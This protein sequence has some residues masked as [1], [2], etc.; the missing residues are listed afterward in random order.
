MK[1]LTTISELSIKINVSSRTLRHWEDMGLFQSIR[2]P[3]SGWR[4]YDSEAV[5]CI[6]ITDLLRRL[7]LSIQDIKKIL[8]Y[9][10][11]D[12]LIIALQSQSN[13]LNKAKVDLNKRRNVISEIIEITKQN[14][15]MSLSLLESIENISTTVTVNHIKKDIINDINN[16]KIY[17]MSIGNSSYEQ[18]YS[19]I[20]LPPMRTAA[21]H[22]YGLEPEDPEPALSWIINNDLL[23]TARFFGFN[24]MPYPTKDNPKFGYDFCVSIPEYIVIPDYL[25]KKRLPGGIYAAFSNECIHINELWN[26]IK[27]GLNNDDWKLNL[28]NERHILEE[29]MGFGIEGD[30]L[31]ISVLVPVKK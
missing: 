18:K 12:E 17:S 10:S 24:T 27:E 25:Y 16:K 2:N 5:S 3:Q 26:K 23:G 21:C 31:R 30:N 6:L 29:H 20:I 15:T 22:H 28:D 19:I 13:K 9:K 1:E 11:I 4:M 14:Q 7:D 8:K